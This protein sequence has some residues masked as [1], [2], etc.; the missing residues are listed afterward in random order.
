MRGLVEGISITPE[1]SISQV[2]GKDEH[3]VWLLL[4]VDPPGYSERW[5]QTHEQ[6]ILPEIPEI[7]TATKVEKI[8]KVRLEY[9][10]TLF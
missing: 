6:Q 5:Q 9:G 1:V 10:V 4:R 3:D 8:R 2:I 7:H